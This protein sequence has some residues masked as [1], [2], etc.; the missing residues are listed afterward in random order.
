MAK[1]KESENMSEGSKEELTVEHK[2]IKDIFQ[3]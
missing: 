3:D 2:K 1:E